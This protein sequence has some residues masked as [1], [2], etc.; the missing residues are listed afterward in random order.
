VSYKVSLNRKT[1]HNQQTKILQTNK[2]T[3][4]SKKPTEAKPRSSPL[5]VGDHLL[6]PI[7]E[8]N[9]EEDFSTLPEVQGSSDTKDLTGADIMEP[10][11][12]LQKDFLRSCIENAWKQNNGTKG[13]TMRMQFHT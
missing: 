1:P 4:A 11:S 7:M 13:N 8:D 10:L 5:E 2:A 9:K 6:S 12:E 3:L